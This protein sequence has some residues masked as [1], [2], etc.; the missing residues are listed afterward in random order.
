MKRLCVVGSLNMDL[1]INLKRFHH[2]GETVI[3]NAINT[4]P[5]GKGGNQAVAAAKLGQDVMMVGI[6]GQDDNGRFYQKRLMAAGI[7]I[8]C[9]GSNAQIPS[10]MAV[11][12]VDDTGENRIAI[13][14]GTNQLVDIAYVDSKMKHMLTYD[15][16]LMQFE[17]AI[18]TV[19][20]LARILHTMGKTVILDPAPVADAPKELY[21]SIDYLTPNSTEL[22][23][24]TGLP[25]ESREQ[26]IHAAEKLLESGVGAVV[27]KLGESGCLYVSRQAI[28]TVP[29]FEVAPVDTT[30]AGDSFNAGLAAALARNMPISDA[31]VFANAVGALS[32]L[33]AGAQS[34][35]PSYEEV[36]RFLGT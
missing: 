22:A 17:I 30:A 24:L 32:T 20:H 16:F 26:A 33:K 6:L 13:V 9:V 2:P 19:C 12:E 29:G 11:I 4:Y 18:E 5:G 27:A 14:P 1:T 21:R 3:A 31:L 36:I 8:S 34:A 25:T 10:G 7:D 15:I 35:M 28:F 23:M